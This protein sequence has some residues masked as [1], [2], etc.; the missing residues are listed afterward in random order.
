MR[1]ATAEEEWRA[2]RS[3]LQMDSKAEHKAAVWTIKK[4]WGPGR[5]GSQ[6]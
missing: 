4:L 3:E 1:S 2:S 6:K 5:S